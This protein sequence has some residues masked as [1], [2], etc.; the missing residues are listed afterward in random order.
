METV[1][2]V[3]AAVVKTITWVL[4]NALPFVRGIIEEFKKAQA[5]KALK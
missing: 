2:K 1:I 3:L 4:T 5:K